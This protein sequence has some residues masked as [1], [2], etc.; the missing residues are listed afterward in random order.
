MP[1]KLSLLESGLAR[2]A[3]VVR[4]RAVYRNFVDAA[5]TTSVPRA[6]NASGAV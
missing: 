1:W 2:E 6:I 5:N 3:S 4:Y